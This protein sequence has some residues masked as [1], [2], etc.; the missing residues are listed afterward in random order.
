[1]DIYTKLM[2]SNAWDSQYHLPLIPE[3]NNPWIFC[4]YVQRLLWTNGDWIPYSDIEK[5]ISRCE[6][7]PGF[8]QRWPGD[9]NTSHDELLGAAFLSPAFSARAVDY[10]SKHNGYYTQ[11]KPTLRD[12]IYRYVFMLPALKAFA[13]RPVNLFL[14]ILLAFHVLWELYFVK[15]GEANDRLKIWLMYPYVKN[16]GL[17]GPV[18]RYWAR[19]WT[20]R[21]VT[22]K[23]MFTQNYLTEVPIMGEMAGDSYD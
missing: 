5:H 10:L 22:P 2:D 23:V 8:I 3:H 14:Q 4:A 17:S 16:L 6:E 20:K 9:N 21:G 19:T 7:E 1:M 15:A 12:N 11:E 18:V 13:N